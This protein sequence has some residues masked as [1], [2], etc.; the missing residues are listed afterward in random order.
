MLVGYDLHWDLVLKSS[1]CCSPPRRRLHNGS[2]LLQPGNRQASSIEQRVKQQAGA[3]TKIK[4]GKE[5]EERGGEE[6]QSCNA[7]AKSGDEMAEG[8]MRVK[9][10]EKDVP[11]VLQYV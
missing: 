2:P 11:K 1:G 6:R 7:K 9:R 8:W 5:G 10:Q 3:G 4:A